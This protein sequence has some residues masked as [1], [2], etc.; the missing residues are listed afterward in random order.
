MS[1]RK[2]PSIKQMHAHHDYRCTM[3]CSLHQQEHFLSAK[4]QWTAP[5]KVH[6]DRIQYH[7]DTDSSMMLHKRYF[8][9]V[10][11]TICFFWAQLIS[12][13]SSE[14]YLVN[15]KWLS[16]FI[17]PPLTFSPQ[18][19]GW[20]STFIPSVSSQPRIISFTERNATALTNIWK[21]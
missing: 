13:I 14:L 4:F 6:D 16:S 15:C 10:P 12:T 7:H 20:Y 3:C 21:N 1:A 11:I 19:K 5:D 17:T 8:V 9:T 2:S 18:I